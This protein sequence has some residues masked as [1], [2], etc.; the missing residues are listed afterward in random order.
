MSEEG[1]GTPGADE[2]DPWATPAQ[3]PAEEEIPEILPVLPLKQS[4]PASKQGKKPQGAKNNQK[5]KPDSASASLDEAKLGDAEAPAAEGQGAAANEEHDPLATPAET[6]T[7]I[8]TTTSRE[9]RPATDRKPT[10][11]RKPRPEKQTGENEDPST[12]PEDAEE[13]GDQKKKGRGYHNPERVMTGGAQRDKLSEEELTERMARMR[14]QNEKI[15]QRRMDV[16]ADEDAFK[17]TQESERLRLAKIRQEQEQVN[18]TREQNAQRKMAKVEN[19]E[20]DAGKRAANPRPA[21]SSGSAADSSRRGRGGGRGASTPRGR[22][23]GRG[24]GAPTEEKSEPAAVG[25]AI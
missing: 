2:Y 4:A 6:T 19:R 21:E 14:E 7:P 16:I 18:R 15:K 11:D 9:K 22:G 12:A 3:P 20:W 23:R 10:R 25:E 13:D 24:D 17:K 5:D 8:D 1:W